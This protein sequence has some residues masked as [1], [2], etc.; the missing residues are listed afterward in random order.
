MVT[1]Y[2]L[3]P[4]M[5]GTATVA[6]PYGDNFT[7][8]IT[9]L[10]RLTTAWSAGDDDNTVCRRYVGAVVFWNEAFRSALIERLILVGLTRRPFTD[11]LVLRFHVKGVTEK[12]DAGN[13]VT[14]FAGGSEGWP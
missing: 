10:P 13:W 6:V 3:W 7:R 9:L 8:V 1:E 2:R 5:S 4:G 12:R 14:T 11:T